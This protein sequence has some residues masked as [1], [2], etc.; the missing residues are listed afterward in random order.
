[1]SEI[2]NTIKH[3]LPN[4][5][6]DLFTLVHRNSAAVRGNPN[7]PCKL[8][9]IVGGRTW[10]ISFI[11]LDPIVKGRPWIDPALDPQETE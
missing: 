9:Q 2:W 10:S 3:S 6:G 11:T 7:W 5:S 8:V 1:M 4:S